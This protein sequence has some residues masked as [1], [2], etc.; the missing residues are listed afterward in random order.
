MPDYNLDTGQDAYGHLSP[1]LGQQL[2]AAATG[3]AAGT[4]VP[5]AVG[6]GAPTILNAIDMFGSFTITGTAASGI[7]AAVFFYNPLP[8][9]PKSIQCG[10]V[11]TAG[12]AVAGIP[13]SGLIPAGLTQ[14]NIYGGAFTAASY[15]VYYQILC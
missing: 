12:G 13:C 11:L 2:T 7:I 10:A 5:G 4:I 15:T 9:T 3:T 8:G 1:M 6:N 14:L